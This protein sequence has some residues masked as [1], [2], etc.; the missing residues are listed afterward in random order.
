MYHKNYTMKSAVESDTMWYSFTLTD[1][2]STMDMDI[3]IK[4]QIKMEVF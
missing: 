2:G 4:L 3:N 1:W